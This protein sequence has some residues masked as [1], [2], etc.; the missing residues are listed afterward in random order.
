MLQNRG[1]EGCARLLEASWAILASK[2]RPGRRLKVMSGTFWSRHGAV[3]GRL[4]RALEGVGGVWGFPWRPFDGPV[5]EF[6][7]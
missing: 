3:L 1:L 5:R 2:V 6:W 7:Y 4:W